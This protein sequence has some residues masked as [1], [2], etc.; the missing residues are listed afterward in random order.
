MERGIAA[1]LW[2]LQLNQI[3]SGVK[4]SLLWVHCNIE[5]IT[6]QVV[7]KFSKSVNYWKEMEWNEMKWNKTK[8]NENY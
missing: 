2:Q 3:V 6:D 1:P 8:W 7:N 4:V 5:N